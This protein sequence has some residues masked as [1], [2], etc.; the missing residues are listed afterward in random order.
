MLTKLFKTDSG[1]RDK[2][3]QDAIRFGPAIIPSP[4]SPGVQFPLHPT[5]HRSSRFPIGGV[6]IQQAAPD[7]YRKSGST[8][9]TLPID[10]LLAVSRE[11]VARKECGT[12]AAL[13]DGRVA[14]LV[15][16]PEL[17]REAMRIAVRGPSPDKSGHI[18]I[19]F[20]D[21]QE[22]NRCAVTWIE[23]SDGVPSGAMDLVLWYVSQETKRPRLEVRRILS[24]DFYNHL[25]RAYALHGLG[26]DS[27][28]GS[29]KRI[30]QIAEQRLK[31]RGWTLKPLAAEQG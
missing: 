19:T 13:P 23:K 24:P 11:A 21:D 17:P 5:V 25:V 28:H 29:T 20:R 16:N 18:D 15:S 4:S 26:D 27:L 3:L 8:F 30:H 1:N 9:R 7:W 12:I 10:P 14:A 2:A 31:M 6:S 22:T